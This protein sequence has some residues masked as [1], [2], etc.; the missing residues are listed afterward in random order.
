MASVVSNQELK[1]LACIELNEMYGYQILQ[2]LGSIMKM[3]SLYGALKSLERKGFVTARWGEENGPG[4]RR[5]Y[6]KISAEGGNVLA[7]E[8]ESL[9][10]AGVF[11]LST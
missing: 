8:R 1:I 5:R 4:G 11:R 6:Y 2:K 9:I 3:G 10:K 7:M